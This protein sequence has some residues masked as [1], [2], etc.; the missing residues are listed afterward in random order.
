MTRL[1]VVLDQGDRLPSGRIRALMYRDLFGKHGFQAS[2]A[3]RQAAP[4][5]AGAMGTRIQRLRTAFNE[6]RILGMARDA[7]IIYL[8]K[9]LSRSF[10][11][12]LR[13]VSKARIVLDFCDAAWL[14]DGPGPEGFAE[15]LRSV[16]AVTTDNEITASFARLHNANCTVVP[17]SPQLE[18]FDRQRE[19]HA[20]KPGG[21]IVLGWL[22][23][24]STAFNLYVV[25]EAL[26]E[27]F[28]RHDNLHLRLVG[29][30]L[31]MSR[32]PAFERVRYSCRPAY[33]QAEMIEE[34]L[35]MHIGLFP[36]Q[37]VEKCR[38]RGILKAAVYMSGEAAV[39]ASPV[40]QSAE[41]IQ[42][43]VNGMLPS[44]SG[45]WIEKLERLIRDSSLRE[46]IARR[47]LEAVRSRFR[48]EQSFATLLPVLQAQR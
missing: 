6:R 16:D 15:I 41:F 36:L 33:D 18:E 38:V 3:D 44:S 39:V 28:R 10:I 1:L 47:G 4:S 43:G 37:D 11:R 17:D 5:L 19:R 48:L 45:E 29:T 13:R 25:W 2:F 12:E 23:S 27:L 20:R 30:G 40:G 32:F 46:S 22:G 8:S 42:D 14:V 31:D 34:V 7:E 9:V 24:P 21:R 26:E 35:G